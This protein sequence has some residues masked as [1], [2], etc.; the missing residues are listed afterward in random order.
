MVMQSEEDD[1]NE[2]IGL[3]LKVIAGISPSEYNASSFSSTKIIFPQLKS[4]SAH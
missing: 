1:E 3:T 4:E 2:R